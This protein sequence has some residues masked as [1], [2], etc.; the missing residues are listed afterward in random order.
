MDYSSR[1]FG[2]EKMNLG[3]RVYHSAMFGESNKFVLGR[4]TRNVLWANLSLSLRDKVN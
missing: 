3:K 1:K 2:S 4:L